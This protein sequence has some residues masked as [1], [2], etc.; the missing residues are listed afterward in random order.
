[1]I[2]TRRPLGQGTPLNQART[3]TD[4]RTQKVHTQQDSSHQHWSKRTT[5]TQDEEPGLSSLLFFWNIWV[6]FPQEGFLLLLRIWS[7]FSILRQPTPYQTGRIECLRR[8][9]YDDPLPDNRTEKDLLQAKKLDSH[10]QRNKTCAKQRTK[11]RICTKRTTNK[12]K[13]AKKQTRTK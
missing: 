8:H 10:K 11:N 9:D 2:C 7:R 3:L 13:S 4:Q 6:F 12:T 5:Q 1:M